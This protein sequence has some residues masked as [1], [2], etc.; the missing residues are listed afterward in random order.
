MMPSQISAQARLENSQV[1]RTLAMLKTRR[2]VMNCQPHSL[3][4]LTSHISCWERRPSV[5]FRVSN[6]PLGSFESKNSLDQCT[7]HCSW[8]RGWRSGAGWRRSRLGQRWHSRYHRKRR[9]GCIP[10]GRCHR[11]RWRLGTMSKG[12]AEMIMSIEL[13]P[14]TVAAMRAMKVKVRANMI[15]MLDAGFHEL[16]SWGFIVL[17]LFFI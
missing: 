15:W 14:R 10:G 2:I 11:P 1:R 17:L 12:D 9:Y 4:L 7:N 13:V 6:R 16:T 8:Y 3:P 5:I